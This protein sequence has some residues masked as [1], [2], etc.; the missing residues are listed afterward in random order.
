MIRARLPKCVVV[1]T[2]G[3]LLT[4]LQAHPDIYKRGLRR[5]KYALRAEQAAKRQAGDGRLPVRRKG[6]L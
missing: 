6:V 1:L 4:M 2:P 5:G 3:E